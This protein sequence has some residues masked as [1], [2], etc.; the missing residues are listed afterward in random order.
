M[1]LTFLSIAEVIEIHHNQILQYGGESG[2][3]DIALLKSALGMPP[4]TFDG[5]FL[6]SDIYEIAAA[7]LYHLVQNHPFVDG[8]KRAGAV[9]CLVFLALNGYDFNAPED[10][11]A[12]MVIAVASGTLSKPEITAYIKK[13]TSKA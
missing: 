3:R 5:R 13:W 6:H 10:D 12:E 7:Y 11:F 4:A 8:N 9:S 2:I 1:E